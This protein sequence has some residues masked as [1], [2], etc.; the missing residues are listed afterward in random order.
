MTKRSLPV[1]V[2]RKVRFTK[3]S[4]LV[5]IPKDEHGLKWYNSQD[6]E[7]FRLELVRDVRRLS[8]EL[9]RTGS[10]ALTP[11]VLLDCMGI[12]VFVTRGLL[13]RMT[14]QKRMHIHAVLSEQLLQTRQGISDPEKLS[15]VAKRSSKSSAKRARKLA[16]GYR[17]LLK[18]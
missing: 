18:K 16:A 5:L 3:F 10:E 14:E 17:A 9:E 4:V 15:K 11:E 12:E 1:S 13:R 8:G 2:L 7:A 6:R